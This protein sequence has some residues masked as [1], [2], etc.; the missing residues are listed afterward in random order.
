MDN[1]DAVMAQAEAQASNFTP[2]NLPA[3][4]AAAPQGAVQA[5]Q[6]PQAPS[7]MGSMSNSGVLADEYLK[8]DK[9]GFKIGDDFKGYVDDFVATIDM[10]EVSAITSFSSEAGGKTDFIKTFD[11]IQTPSG[12]SFNQEM[13]R[14]GSRAGAKNR[15]PYPT[16]EIPLVL[17]DD[18]KD[19]KSALV[20]EADA[21]VCLTPSVTGYKE[22][23]KFFK[24]LVKA[25][26]S[27]EAAASAEVKVKVTCKER[28]NTANTWGVATFE[29]LEVLN[30]GQAE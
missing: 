8:V 24:S 19:P 26:G 3:A 1:L 14:L 15:G 7:L 18:I 5:Y 12:Q 17:V 2:T 25:T 16:A 20:V 6:Q 23:Q 9:A 27:A 4:V 22:F 10:S 29:L 21:L 11:G 30:A 13:N 28:S